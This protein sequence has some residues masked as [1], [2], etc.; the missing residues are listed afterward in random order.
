MNFEFEESTS[1]ASMLDKRKS[2][3]AVIAA[4]VGESGP[5]L[6]VEWERKRWSHQIQQFLFINGT[7]KKKRRV[8][9]AEIQRKG[10]KQEEIRQKNRER[11]L[12]VNV[13]AIDRPMTLLEASTRSAL[14]E[15][16]ESRKRFN[17]RGKQCFE[18]TSD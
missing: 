1:S 4:F 8:K 9:K 10:Q 16:F 11:D 5:K 3:V 13:G 15:Y 14:S 2:A 17:P 6:P 7:L 18:I 12:F